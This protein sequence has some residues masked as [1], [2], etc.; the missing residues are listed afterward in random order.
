MA[1]RPEL[2]SGRCAD[3]FGRSV[4]LMLNL[5]VW[6]DIESLRTF[7][8]A[9]AH[10]HVMRRRKAWLRE[11]PSPSAFAMKHFYPTGSRRATTARLT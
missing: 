10:L 2:I 3:S 4:E 5:S 8:Y 7:T 6:E 9:G 11:G 1:F